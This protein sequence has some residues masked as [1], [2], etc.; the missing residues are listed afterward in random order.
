[1]GLLD[2]LKD[3][4]CRLRLIRAV[5][6]ETRAPRKIT[7]RVTSLKDLKTEVLRQDRGHVRDELSWSPDKV[8][9]AAGIR[10]GAWTVERL[11]DFLRTEPLR[12]MDRAAARQA[13]LQALAADKA[14]VGD[15]VQDARSRD[16][17]LQE[18]ADRAQALVQGRQDLR[19]R[20]REALERQ[21]GQLK[22]ACGALDAANQEDQQALRQWQAG[23]AAYTK[24][25]TWAMGFLVEDPG[26]F[27]AEPK[28]S[29]AG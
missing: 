7:P 20:Q 19:S 14:G 22:E 1:V 2:R 6:K 18:A 15:L 10:P 16:R 13:V 11:R 26:G 12:S 23:K 29:S 25:M 28:K 21:I 4:G 27:Q 24:D 3:L 8:F 5:P 17:A 9:A